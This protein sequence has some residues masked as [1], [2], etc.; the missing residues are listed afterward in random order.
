MMTGCGGGGHTAPPTTFT[1]TVHSANPSSGVVIG[2]GTSANNLLQQGTT[3]FTI[4][5]IPFGATY[6]LAAPATTSGITFS[7]W[8]GCTTSLT[9]ICTVTVSADT[10]V[11]ATYVTPV[12]TT[13]TITVTP[14]ANSITTAQ[15]L[16]VT[17]AVAGTP[18]PT[19]SVV[20]TS[21]GYTSAATALASGSA[22][23]NIPAGALAAGN[24]TLT[25]AYTPDAGSSSVYNSASGTGSVTV[26]ASITPSVTVGLSPSTVT[27]A[28]TDTATITVYSTGNPTP[29]GSVV[30]S[31]GGYTSAATA[32]ASGS[33]TILIP[34]GALAVGSI[35]LTATYTPDA[36]STS[37]YTGATGQS[38]VTVTNP[39]FTLTVNS[40]NPPSGV[41]IGASPADVNS[42]SSGVTASGG[43]AL[44][45]TYGVGAAV[46]LTAPETSGS[47][48]FSSW[49][50]CTSVAATVCTVALNA[51]TIVTANYLAPS[52]VSVN[53]SNPGGTVTDQI[54]GM[55]LA[56]W[57]DDVGNASA[58]NSAFATAGIKAIRWPGG[59]W[60]DDYHWGMGGV[61]PYMC[62]SGTTNHGWAGY[63][64][65]AQFVAA[66]PLGGSY[67]LALT[68]D[69]GTNAA[70]N[71]PGD[72]AEAAAW[73][74]AAKGMTNGANLSHITV[75]NEEYGSWETDYHTAKNDPTTYANAVV[76][77][78]YPDIKAADPNVLVGVDVNPGEASNWDSIV[79]N[80]AKGS[81]DFVEYHYYPQGPFSES[82]TYLVHSAAQ[83]LTA[84]IN[85]VKAELN[86]AGEP[87]TPIFVGEIGSVYSNPGKQSMSITQGLYA[88]QVLGEMMNDGVVRATWWIGFGNCNGSSGN[89]SASLY[90]WQNFGAYNVFADGPTDVNC[91]GAGPIGTLSPT[92]RAFQLFSNVAITGESVLKALVTGNTT[93]VRAY[94]ATHSGGT[95]TAL[96]LFNLNQ[97]TPEPVTV[98]L[99]GKS[100][101][102]G[103]T[104]RTYS[105]GIYD[106]S[107]NNV[108]APPTTT[109]L[110]TQNLPLTLTL[111]PWS[112][113]VLILQ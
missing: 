28:Q 36:A 64:T 22:I 62:Q 108:W 61:A 110:G 1:I 37:I 83:G 80:T 18:T 23:I 68:A 59:S 33:A 40:T 19:G 89:D 74:T 73:V 32:L 39:T 47:A 97:N 45:L 82:D 51:N 81:Y 4:P 42:T 113:N 76:S 12:K 15:A 3:S 9:V 43:A 24:D 84:N 20:L 7:A 112:M 54:L 16:S 2:Y 49:T 25:A 30:L 94:A 103:V 93:D 92:A 100:T 44:V 34:A 99:S 75:G 21:G 91:A 55:N 72:P 66:I 56:A 10:T 46:T 98:T 26:T 96:V 70:C 8:T 87:N 77:G 67:D 88:G 14:S 27:T 57:Y 86:T 48:A 29:T 41:T 53:L 65:F 107:K 102:A 105:K 106:Q 35:T 11:T 6:V 101:S 111:D 90:G 5:S 31:G 52:A 38:P 95:E 109:D 58:I 50:G 17:V 104:V 71:G 60:S 79:L 69:Y 63:S 13:P 78:Y 85:T